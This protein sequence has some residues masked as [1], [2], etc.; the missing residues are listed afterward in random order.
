LENKIVKLR[1]LQMKKLVVREAFLAILAIGAVALVHGPGWGGQLENDHGGYMS[2]PGD[3]NMYGY[4]SGDD[5]KFF[6]E[7]KDLRKEL[8]EKQIEY[9]KAVRDLTTDEKTI[10]MLQKEINDLQDKITEKAPYTAR[11]YGYGP[12]WQ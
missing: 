4:Y 9:A 11:A 12:Y 7:T 6:D 3:S 1:R 8:N 2:G 5:Q 10:A